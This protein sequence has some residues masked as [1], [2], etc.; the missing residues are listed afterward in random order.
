MYHDVK[1]CDRTETDTEKLNRKTKVDSNRQTNGMAQ[2]HLRG[3][4]E[5]EPDLP[6][7]EPEKNQDI[8]GPLTL[9]AILLPVFP[10]SG[11]R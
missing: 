10:F 3:D 7:Q 2:K 11:P 5:P 8:S 9:G 6:Q 4:T 1:V